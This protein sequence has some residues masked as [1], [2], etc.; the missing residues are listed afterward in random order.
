MFFRYE[1][2]IKHY[3]YLRGLDGTLEANLWRLPRRFGICPHCPHYPHCPRFEHVFPNLLV[4]IYP[5]W[6]NPYPHLEIYPHYFYPHF[7]L[8]F[9]SGE[10]GEDGEG[11]FRILVTD[12]PLFLPLVFLEM[13]MSYP[14]PSRMLVIMTLS[15]RVRELARLGQNLPGSILYS[16][17][18]LFR[19]VKNSE[20]GANQHAGLSFK[21]FCQSFRNL[22][23]T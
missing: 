15:F 4:R 22:A 20:V 6:N 9:S 12:N 10:D 17:T 8:D 19:S 18:V 16:A 2:C 21:S 14:R 13:V 7:V 5:H 3:C 23:M 1:T 11:I